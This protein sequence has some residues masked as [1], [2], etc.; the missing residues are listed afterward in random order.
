M[1]KDFAKSILKAAKLPVDEYYVADKNEL[2]VNFGS[3]SNLYWIA[4][5]LEQLGIPRKKMR[6]ALIIET[7]EPLHED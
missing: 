2:V 5:K 1:T 3:V 7:D 6:M 4:N